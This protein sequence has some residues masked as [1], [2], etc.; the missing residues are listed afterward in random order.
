MG[1]G[2]ARLGGAHFLA[3]YRLSGPGARWVGGCGGWTEGGWARGAGPVGAAL[4]KR[5][6]R[7]HQGGGALPRSDTARRAAPSRL[8]TH[9]RRSPPRPPPPQAW[10][11]RQAAARARVQQ[12]AG[13]TAATAGFGGPPGAAAGGVWGGL[14]GVF[15][16]HVDWNATAEGAAKKRAAAA[17]AAGGGAPR[18]PGAAGRVAELAAKAAQSARLWRMANS[19]KGERRMLSG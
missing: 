6:P 13:T 3:G 15:N 16:Q 4:L 10:H 1:R 12:S 14:S 2:T 7:R 8:K 5:N 17:A 18:A 19:I 11:R 9:P